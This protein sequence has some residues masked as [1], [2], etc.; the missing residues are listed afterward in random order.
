MK[1]MIMLR[2]AFV[3]LL[4]VFS[5]VTASAQSFNEMLAKA[6]EGDAEAQVY[7]AKAYF[8]GEI[9]AEDLALSA[10][11]LSKAAEQ[12]NL[13]AQYIMGYFYEEG[14]GV[15][16]NYT[17]A[18]EWYRKAADAGYAQAQCALAVCYEN[19]IGVE[20]NYVEANRLYQLAA[21]QG[22]A[23]AQYNLGYNY[24]N[25]V[26]VAKDMTQAVKWYSMAAEQG[27]T[28]A[29]V[30]I[31]KYYYAK[32]GSNSPE[33]KK[34]CRVAADAGVAWAQTMVG[35]MYFYG[36]GVAQNYRTAA[37]WYL[38]AANQ[39]DIEGTAS[40]GLCRYMGYGVQPN[41]Y[42]GLRLLMW[43]AEKGSAMAQFNVGY[44]CLDEGDPVEALKWFRLSAKQNYPESQAYIG[45]CYFYGYGVT[46]NQYE[47]FKWFKLAADQGNLF[48]KGC[49][50]VCYYYGQGV[51]RNT[52]KGLKLLRESAQ[53]GCE[54][55]QDALYELGYGW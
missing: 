25:G 33:V 44:Y 40:Y 26:G 30:E 6:Q 10:M 36:D 14:Y 39:D 17:K 41:P 31:A 21:E 43:A 37:N 42:E 29:Q 19:S 12:G 55:A 49:L 11:W 53:G 38:M 18:A 5:A 47:A 7:V 22:N 27:D 32:S 46:K 13:E 45:L 24:S 28:D 48:G 16:K 54:E 20:E 50:G 4:V 8:G 9:V 15:E 23:I 3:A 34:Y 51:S 1:L 2:T 52:D 35:D